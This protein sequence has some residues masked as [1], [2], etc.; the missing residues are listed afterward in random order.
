MATLELSE[1]IRLLKQAT[2]KFITE[3]VEPRVHEIEEGGVMPDDI[4]A[5]M[6]EMGYF[7]ML[8]PEEYGGMGL[9]LHAFTEVMTEIARGHGSVFEMIS[10]NNSLTGQGIVLSGTPEQK[11]KYLP[12]IASGD[13]LCAF[14]LTEPGAGSDAQA[15]T[16]RAVRDGDDWVINGVKHFI[17][18]ADIAHVTMVMAVTDAEKRGRGGITAFLVDRG[19]PGMSIGQIQHTLVGDLVHP[20]EV[21]FED[22]R[23]PST[24]VVGEVGFGFATAMQALD[25]GRLCVA[26]I[27]LG[28]AERLQAD[29]IA[30]AKDRVTFGK[31]LAER[32][33]IQA[34]IADN[35]IE[36]Y[37][38]RNMIR[39]TAQMHD[40]GETTT[41]EAAMTKVYA[42]EMASR[43]ADRAF[44]V[45]G[46][47]AYIRES[48]IGRAFASLRVLRIVEGASEILRIRIARTLLR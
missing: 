7:G 5:T 48:P 23:V 32:Q 3:M 46:G 15:I 44:Q 35:E 31:P 14:A 4:L 13:M 29:T 38:A 28:G 12:G 42:T 24:S 8:I 1:D 16:T 47:N 10:G 22:C 26:S 18:R 33:L 43:V 6:K 39:Q 21:V 11:E 27:A 19:T 34:M 2:R 37:A 30:H 36:L 45:F 17:T 41:Q 20:C 25:Y 9:S 40:A